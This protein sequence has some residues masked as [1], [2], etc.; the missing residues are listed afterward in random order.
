MDNIPST[1]KPCV[2]TDKLTEQ[3]WEA[4]TKDNSPYYINK[5]TGKGQWECPRK[6]GIGGSRK[7]KQ[8]KN[9]KSKSKSKT[10]NRRK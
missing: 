3:G 10:I 8:R 1:P 9:K 5:K 6:S 4:T 7:R 2:L